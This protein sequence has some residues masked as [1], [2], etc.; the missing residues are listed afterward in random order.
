MVELLT[1]YDLSEILIFIVLL[2]VAFKAVSSFI[3]WA[4]DKRR[5]VTLKEMQPDEL[6][7]Q[8][9]QETKDR[10][11]QIRELKIQKE[12]EGAELRQ[13][14]VGIAA[15]VSSLTDKINLLVESDKDDIKAFITREYHYFC[16]QKGWIDDYSMDCIERRYNHYVEEK[17]NSFVKELME[18]LRALPRKPPK[19]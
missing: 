5:K 4:R 18:H 1:T 11:Q 15:Q 19:N 13:Q 7:K 16:E 2:A 14:I 6:A 17:G 10:E 3:D 12:K 9:A 8:I